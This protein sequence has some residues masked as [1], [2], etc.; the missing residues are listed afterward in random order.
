MALKCLSKKEQNGGVTW[1]LAQL[2]EQ[3]CFSL[4]NH[5]LYSG[6]EH[7]HNISPP[8][9]PCSKPVLYILE[10]RN[11]QSDVLSLW[12]VSCVHFNLTDDRFVKFCAV[13]HHTRACHSTQGCLLLILGLITKLIACNH[14]QGFPFS[15]RVSYLADTEFIPASFMALRLHKVVRTHVKSFASLHRCS[16]LS[17]NRRTMQHKC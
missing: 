2:N 4:H 5:S 10:R 7:R 12:T 1:Q 13:P 6:A 17:Y 16:V 3:F 8:R 11:I 14:V 15:Y 9:V